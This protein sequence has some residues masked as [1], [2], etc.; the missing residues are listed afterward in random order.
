VICF[1]FCFVCVFVFVFVFVIA[2]GQR[3][4]DVMFGNAAGAMTILTR[5][6]GPDPAVVTLVGR[7]WAICKLHFSHSLLN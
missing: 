3:M 7:S 5:P 1:V 4:T 6:L 2:C